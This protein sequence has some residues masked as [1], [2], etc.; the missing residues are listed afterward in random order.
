MRRVCERLLVSDLRLACRNS[1]TSSAAISNHD[2][3]E[4]PI[5][6]GGPVKCPAEAAAPAPQASRPFSAIPG[7]GQLSM[8][9]LRD[10]R[11]SMRRFDE[12]SIRGYFGALVDLHA[13]YGDVV[14]V[15]Q[16]WGRGAVVHIFDPED[17][18]KVL[19]ADGRQPHIVPLQETTQKYREMKGMNPGLGN[20]N[21]EEWY[22]LRSAVQQAMMRP[23]AVLQYLPFVNQVADDLIK[24]I[25]GSLDKRGEADMR[26]ISG[27]WALE[28]AGLTVFEKRLGAFDDNMKWA[29]KL[30]AI[31]REIFQLS[32]KL[33]F[34]APFYKL[35]STPK[36]RKMVELEDSFY[37]EAMTLIEEAIKKLKEKATAGSSENLRFASH[38][39]NKD[40][41]SDSDVA[42]RF[43]F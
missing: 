13:M 25:N 35:V 18:K 6:S 7:P 22:R 2:A 17:A 29:D 32:A 31:N 30:V 41:L 40:E 9:G 34:S 16:G 33:K 8:V 37:A 23:Q 4:C 3:T 43:N 19:M 27:R 10:L 1:A 24:H 15:E 39:V 36:W 28:A 5:T 20:L 26:L 11:S 12:T 21:G 14:R 42:V 38:L